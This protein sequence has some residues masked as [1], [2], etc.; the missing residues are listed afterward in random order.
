MRR[1]TY[2]FSIIS[3]ALVVAACAGTPSS[4]TIE[5]GSGEGA[6]VSADVSADDDDSFVLSR[7]PRRS[8]YTTSLP[9]HIEGKWWS[10]RGNHLGL[11][12]AQVR[13]R[14]SRISMVRPPPS[15]WD[16]QTAVEAVSVW[17]AVC[18][19]CH[20]G[21]RRLKDALDMQAPPSEWGRGEGLFFGR[22]RPYREIFATIWGGGPDKDNGEPSEMPAWREK[23]PRELIWSLIWFLEV[24]SGGSEGR[25]PPS[26][27]PRQGA[28]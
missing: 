18:N 26:L 10:F 1:R 22:R 28:D 15:F 23:I 11:S 20:G 19:E 14:D 12:P 13:Q 4:R 21:R 9:I 3:T 16:N 5:P 7:E 25:F 8:D 24:Q 17:T 6:D 27:Y 2:R